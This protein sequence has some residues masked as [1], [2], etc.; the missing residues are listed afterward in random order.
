M[1]DPATIFA[2]LMAVLED[3][4]AKR[5]KDSY[6]VTLFDGGVDRIGAKIIEEAAEVVEAARVAKEDERA[7]LVHEAADLV[8]HL[9]VMLARCGVSLADVELELARRFGVSGLEEKKRRGRGSEG[10]R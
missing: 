5:P 1:S 9:F 7:A 10:V 4:K 2:E 3:R 8:Y 6:T